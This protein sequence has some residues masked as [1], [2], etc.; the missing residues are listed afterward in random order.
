MKKKGILGAVIT[1]RVAA[2]VV[3]GGLEV[4]SVFSSLRD[5][6]AAWRLLVVLRA[7]T[8]TSGAISSHTHPANI[9]TGAQRENLNLDQSLKGEYSQP[10]FEA[11]MCTNQIYLH[12][13]KVKNRRARPIG[14]H[15]NVEL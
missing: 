8:Q 3:L 15:L 9:H 14:C 1:F 5:S 12:L 4:T 11:R 7:L 13:F 10:V 2:D 6:V